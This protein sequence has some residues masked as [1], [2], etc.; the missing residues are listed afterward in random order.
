MIYY[1]DEARASAREEI[2]NALNK[3]GKL[4]PTESFTLME[5]AQAMYHLAYFDSVLKYE[6]ID[7]D[8]KRWERE[9]KKQ[10]EQH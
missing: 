8:K 5:I 3:L 1:S 10:N 9:R 6:Q 2:S 7:V 4:K